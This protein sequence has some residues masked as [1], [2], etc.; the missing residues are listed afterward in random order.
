MIRTLQ[1]TKKATSAW[2]TASMLAGALFA[3]AAPAQLESP[4]PPAAQADPAAAPS[5]TPATA[6]LAK[7][8]DKTFE[9]VLGL[10]IALVSVVMGIGVAIIAVWCDYKK[11]QQL[12]IF[13]HQ[14]H[15]AAI[16]K[17]L[18]PPPFP[19][20][21]GHGDEGSRPSAP[22][23][24]VKGGVFWLAIGIGLAIFLSLQDDIDIHPAI[25][26]IPIAIGFASLA[27]HFIESRQ[28]KS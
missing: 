13:C 15:M 14:E 23:N 5:P 19:R 26:A 6:Q 3:A 18:E 25:S 28:R 27:W 22:G 4:A 8:N 7:K 1:I 9:T 20:E 12:L 2:L 24:A 21:W 11:R 17:G 16:E 10:T